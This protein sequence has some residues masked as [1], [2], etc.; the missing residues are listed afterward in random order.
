MPYQS[1]PPSIMNLPS[2]HDLK[3]VGTPVAGTLEV[4][5]TWDSGGRSATIEFGDGASDT[6]SDEEASHTYAANGEY[7]ATVRSPQATDS[8]VIDLSAAEPEVEEVPEPE[9]EE[10]PAAEPDEALTPIEEAE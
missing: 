4:D 10:V 9:P 5:Y 7:T 6:N 3:L 2:R 1:Y 8:A